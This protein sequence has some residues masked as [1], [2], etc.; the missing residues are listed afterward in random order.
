MKLFKWPQAKIQNMSIPGAML[1]SG[2]IVGLSVF[3]TTWVFFGG[4]NNRQ[5]LSTPTPAAMNRNVQQ[6]PNA[7]T[8]QQIQLMQQQQQQRAD[9]L[10]K[11]ATSTQPTTPTPDQQTA[12]KAPV[13]K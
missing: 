6:Q 11:Q 10:K 4:D 9:L 3:L 5:K 7:L 12:P 1:L 13:K 8:P 2:L